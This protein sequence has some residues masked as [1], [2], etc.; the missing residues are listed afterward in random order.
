VSTR[1]VDDIAKQ[2]G[3]EQISRSQVSRMAGELDE[4]VANW[5]ARPL[6]SGPYPFVW[7]DALT[8]KVRE[9]GRVCQTAVL[10]AT[11]V[12]AEGNR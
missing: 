2:M 5:R 10:V 12:N 1:R 3:I 4:L 7:I 9:G 8:M 6:D 11:A